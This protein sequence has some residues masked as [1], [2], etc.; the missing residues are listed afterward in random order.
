MEKTKH[1]FYQKG[2]DEIF[3]II[4][5]VIFGL[6]VWGILSLFGFSF[7]IENEGIVKYDDCRQIITLKNGDWQ[8]YTKKFTCIYVKTKSGTVMSGECVHIVN[9]GSFFG[10]S[11]T[12]ATAYVYEKKQGGNCTDPTH[13]YLTYDDM[14]STIKYY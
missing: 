7:G 9:D 4:V 6:V 10:G 3:G 14:C 8:T 1:N 12:C 13:P 11:H 2:N 5:L